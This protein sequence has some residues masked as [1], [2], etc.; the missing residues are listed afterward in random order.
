LNIEL[1][2]ADIIGANDNGIKTECNW[3]CKSRLQKESFDNVI[4]E[5]T[6]EYFKNIFGKKLVS[7]IKGI[8]TN[9]KLIIFYEKTFQIKFLYHG[10]IINQ[11]IENNNSLIQLTADFSQI[12]NGI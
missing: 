9:E 4:D 7:S 12:S 3:Y 6:Y 10:Q 2:N 1:N 5:R 8:I 11:G